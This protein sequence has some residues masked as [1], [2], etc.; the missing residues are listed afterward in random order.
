MSIHVDTMILAIINFLVLVVILNKFLY[1]P[2]TNILDERKKEVMRNLDSAE[3][4]KKEAEKAKEEYLKQ[5]EN[6][7]KEANEIISKAT[8]LGEETKNEIISEARNEA[9]KISA[10][11]QEEIRLEKAKP[12]MS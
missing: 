11:A 1:K 2:I 12:L 7:R 4:A 5:L 6:A 10:K 8:K 9:A 3:A